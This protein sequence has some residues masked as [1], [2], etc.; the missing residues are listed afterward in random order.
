MNSKKDRITFRLSRDL[1][2]KIAEAVKKDDT[3]VSSFMV[4]LIDEYFRTYSQSHPSQ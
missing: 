4:Y 2:D 3:N 1:R